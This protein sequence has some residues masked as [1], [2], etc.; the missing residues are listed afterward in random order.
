MSDRINILLESYLSGP[1]DPA[2]KAELAGLLQTPEGEKQFS[3][4]F[5]GQMRDRTFESE[6]SPDVVYERLMTAL[7]TQIRA[8][9]RIHRLRRWMA[10]A[11]AVLLIASTYFALRPS[12]SSP[13][14]TALQD[15]A[16]GRTGAIL[17]LA[18]GSQVVLDS[19]GNGTIARQN[20]AVIVMRN[21][22]LYYD[23]TGMGA[24][25][26]TYNTM[27]VP[28][29][30]TFRLTM[31]D[32]SGV[33]L[34]AASSIRYPTAFT[35]DRREVEITGEVYFEVAQDPRKPFHVRTGRET[36]I[37]VLGTHFNVQA[38]HHTEATLLQ[39]SIRVGNGLVGKI[40]EKPGQQA[41]V[42]LKGI[43]LINH[44]DTTQTMAW[45]NGLFNFN[46]LR[47]RAVMQQL[48]R[49]YDIEVIYEKN[50][51]DIEF[52]GEIN[53]NIS[54]AGVLK[55]LQLSDVHFKI[56]GRKLIVLP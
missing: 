33:W 5:D 21:G 12:P 11:A 4:I 28:K 39:G 53:R 31:P 15:I 16:P 6:D 37:E 30:R 24:G 2:V 48:E 26:V 17:T 10:A 54:L 14:V 7:S 50:V 38:Y 35:G 44:V 32:G 49:W 52:Y 47:L 45:K 34:N 8:K 1:P 51:P 19:A 22:Q 23:L 42:N 43:T 25:P 13:T 20:G 29:G 27:T 40:L 18:D 9:K 41:K 3:D 36:T 46:G 55:A 56:E